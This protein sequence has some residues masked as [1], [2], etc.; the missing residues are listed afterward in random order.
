MNESSKTTLAL[1]YVA[2]AV[3]NRKFKTLTT[4]IEKEEISQFN[5][6]FLHLNKRE[7]EA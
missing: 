7:K 1:W 6:L 4:Y 3:L 5:D 2:K